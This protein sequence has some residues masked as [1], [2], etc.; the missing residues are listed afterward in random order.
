MNNSRRREAA[1]VVYERTKLAETTAERLEAGI[2]LGYHMGIAHKCGES[3]GRRYRDAGFS[4]AEED[5]CEAAAE[6]AWK[7][8][9]RGVDRVILDEFEDAFFRAAAKRE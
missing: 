5:I 2:A 8:M 6:A 7:R 3:A 9:G 1:R 4:R